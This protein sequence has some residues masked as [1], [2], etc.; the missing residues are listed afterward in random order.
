MPDFNKYA[1]DTPYIRPELPK[2]GMSL[3]VRPVYDYVNTFPKGVDWSSQPD[4]GDASA[5]LRMGINNPFRGLG[6][7]PVGPGASTSY[8]EAKRYNDS[9]MMFMP[10]RDNEDLY[11][12]HQ[13][14][15]SSVGSGLSRLVLTTGTKLGT[16]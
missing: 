13:G 15:W 12:Q 3:I 16:G 1:T 2:T 4:T 5:Y 7:V 11:A 8:T 10:T 6:T 14:F 9:D